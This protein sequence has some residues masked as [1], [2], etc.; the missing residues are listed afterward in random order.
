MIR[1]SGRRDAAGPNKSLVYKDDISPFARSRYRGP[2]CRHTTAHDKNIRFKFKIIHSAA[3]N[4]SDGLSYATTCV[5][6]S[7]QLRRETGTAAH[8]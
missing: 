5:R 1:A 3:F 2:S 8:F 7:P 4:E 6:G